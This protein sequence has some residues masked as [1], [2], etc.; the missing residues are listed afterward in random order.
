MFLILLMHGAN[1]KIDEILL[2]YSP[3]TGRDGTGGEWRGTSTCLISALDGGGWSIP[4]PGRFTPGKWPRYPLYNE[5]HLLP[6]SVSSNKCIIN[7][8]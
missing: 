3:K 8:T 7:I 6:L 2:K 1:R 4:R 5:Q